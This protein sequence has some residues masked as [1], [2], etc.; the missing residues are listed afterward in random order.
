MTPAELL[1]PI[2]RPPH[3][4]TFALLGGS[5]GWSIVDAQQVAA[6]I[7]S[8]L[9]LLPGADR[10]L[11]EPSGSFG[12]LVPPANVAINEACEIWLVL[13]RRPHQAIRSL[14]MQLRSRPV[15]STKVDSRPWRSAAI[16]SFYPPE[17]PSRSALC[18]R[19]ASMPNG[20]LPKASR[21]RG[22]PPELS[23]IRST[24]SAVADPANSGVHRFSVSGRNHKFI[25]GI[26]APR[27]LACDCHGYIYVV[28]DNL[29]G[30]AVL[31]PDGNPFPTS[32]R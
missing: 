32:R 5:L 10:S 12:G 31:D 18:P 28:R 22:L 29:P 25:G 11:A 13:Q 1:P 26:A 17:T 6:E 15:L 27:Y 20:I 23:S 3:D 30:A 4:P 8:H 9:A 19:S 2:P 21:T 16:S 14:W 7:A 24:E